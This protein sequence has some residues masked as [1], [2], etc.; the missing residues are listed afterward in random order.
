[1]I[2]NDTYG[3]ITREE[4]TDMRAD[5]KR[6]NMLRVRKIRADHLSECFLAMFPEEP[7]AYCTCMDWSPDWT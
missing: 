4:L 2:D 7:T 6:S 5:A 3:S 1:M